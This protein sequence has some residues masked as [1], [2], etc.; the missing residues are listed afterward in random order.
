MSTA[1][2]W[3]G[4]LVMVGP[5]PPGALFGEPVLAGPSLTAPPGASVLPEPSLAGRPK[6]L[7]VLAPPG[8]CLAAWEKSI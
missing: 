2:K 4:A 7:G 6:S 8:P 3:L 1:G 5:L